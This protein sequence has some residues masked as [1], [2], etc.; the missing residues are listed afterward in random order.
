MGQRKNKS[1]LS[2]LGAYALLAFCGSVAAQSLYK[3]TDEDGNVHYGDK[4]PVGTDDISI[5]VEAEGPSARNTITKIPVSIEESEENGIA[6]FV[7]LANEVFSSHSQTPSKLVVADDTLWLTFED[8]LLSFDPSTKTS[9]KYKL[10]R[11]RFGLSGQRMRISGDHLIFS[12]TSRDVSVDAFYLYNHMTDAYKEVAISTKSNYIISYED[13]YD[14][15]IFGFAFQRKSIV[16]YMDV[17]NVV[18]ES[19]VE[20]FVYQVDNSEGGIHALSVNSD[21]IWYFSG[22]KKNCSVGFFDKQESIGKS[23]NNDEIG[24]PASNSCAFIVADDDEVWVTSVADRRDATL[25]VYDI[26]SG[27]WEVL[28]RSANDIDFSVSPLQMDTER[29]YFNY[30][31]RLIA[32]NRESR[33]AKA[34][35]IDGDRNDRQ[36]QCIHAFNIYDDHVW[37]LVFEPFNHRKYPVLYKIP[38]EMMNP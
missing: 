33:V 4:P 2:R 22:Y 14:D 26:G 38:A 29:V 35:A 17:R 19:P 7:L 9:V 1:C 23:F 28:E 21:S 8:S 11:I 13:R 10:E 31:D 12:P 34:L 18:D 25:A 6:R 30:C 5:A 36:T 3:W 37:A 20:E 24:I 15:G 27:T 32:V 16:Q